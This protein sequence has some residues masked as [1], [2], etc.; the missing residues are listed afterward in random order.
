MRA[1]CPIP[2]LI[3]SLATVTLS[4]FW[5][6]RKVRPERSGIAPRGG[7]IPPGPEAGAVARLVVACGLCESSGLVALVLFMLAG[8]TV[9]LAAFALSWISLAAHFPGDRRW[10]RLVAVSGGAAP[11]PMVRG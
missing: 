2:S 8:N 9:A 5:A 3:Y 11:S 6:V 1:V 4:W 10:T 7:A